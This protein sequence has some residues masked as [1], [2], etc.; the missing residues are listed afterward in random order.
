M[1]VSN[2][3]Q[4]ETYLSTNIGG[5][6]LGPD[7]AVMVEWTQP[8]TVIRGYLY[9][10]QSGPD[11]GNPGFEFGV[12]ITGSGGNSSPVSIPTISA[13]GFAIL[14]LMLA[15]VALIFLRSRA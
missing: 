6:P 12:G 7:N 3:F 13:A 5:Q 2:L 4:I 10:S 14:V 1:A 8:V 9:N 11:A 15:G